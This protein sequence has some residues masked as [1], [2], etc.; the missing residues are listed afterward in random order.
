[1]DISQINPVNTRPLQTV[2][3]IVYDDSVKKRENVFFYYINDTIITLI[4]CP[5]LIQQVEFSGD[6]ERNVPTYGRQI[7]WH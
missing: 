3:Q 5:L 4:Y 1:M 7:F 6:N 2:F